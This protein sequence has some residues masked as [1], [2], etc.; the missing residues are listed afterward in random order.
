[1]LN[2]SVLEI[3]RTFTQEEHKKFEDFI[4][5]PYF[6][7][8]S[9]VVKLYRYMKR[10]ALE[11]NSTELGKEKIWNVLY[12]DKEFNYGVIKNLIFGLTKCAESF[13]T[14]EAF[15]NDYSDFNHCFLVTLLARENKNLFKTKFQAIMKNLNVNN[16][17]KNIIADDYCHIMSRIFLLK[18]SLSTQFDRHARMED[19]FNEHTTYLASSFLTLFL[20][21]CI[22]SLNYSGS[23]NYKKDENM[24]YKFVEKADSNN[25]ILEMIES[26]KPKHEELYEIFNVY[27]K[28]YK[29][30]FDNNSTEKYFDFK[31]SLAS[32]S[33]GF[34]KFDREILYSGLRNSLAK[35]TSPEIN[36][37]TETMEMIKLKMRDD[38]ILNSNGF[39]TDIEFVSIIQS[40]CDLGDSDF[41]ED[42]TKKYLKYIPGELRENDL[43]FSDAHYLFTKNEFK[44]SLEKISEIDIDFFAMKY[45]LKNLQMMNHYELN[46]YN[47]FLLVS[48][49]YKHFLSKNKAITEKW[50]KSQSLFNNFLNRLFKLGESFDEFE[51]NKLNNEIAMSVIPKKEWL[52]RKVD[53]LKQKHLP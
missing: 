10:F 42:F 6:N 1:M 24:I 3:L 33:S 25:L 15:Q 29:S 18:W 52:I 51:M 9:G 49:S 31:K 30:L 32:L 47:S 20:Q 35:T 2:T 21:T 53:E 23:Y 4:L 41:I 46:D 13:I 7:K 8:K 36:K 39:L 5:S 45:Y 19:E 22:N 14:L 43:R 50:N 34:S 27:Y 28:Y 26:L 17:D 12:K 48:D 37:S 40:A 11:F 44:K 38:L 16:G